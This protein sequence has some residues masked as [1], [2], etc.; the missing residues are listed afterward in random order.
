M[1]TSPVRSATWSIGATLLSV[2]RLTSSFALA[3]IACGTLPVVNG[4]STA[5]KAASVK[6][7][8][9]CCRLCSTSRKPGHA[10]NIAPVW[11]AACDVKACTRSTLTG[12]RSIASAA[13]VSPT[14]F[15]TTS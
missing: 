5:G 15:E 14:G 7:G 3:T 8:H 1:M 4:A 13:V 2:N 10:S 6:R 12:V 11:Q 9:A